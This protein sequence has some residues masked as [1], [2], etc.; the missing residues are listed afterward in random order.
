ME[1]LICLR[2]GVN[3]RFF[4]PAIIKKFPRHARLF[5]F[6]FFLEKKSFDNLPASLKKAAS[7]LPGRYDLKGI[8]DIFTSFFFFEEFFPKQ[9]WVVIDAGA[10]KGIYTEIC[11][12][13]VEN[14][15][16]I[17]SI[18]P[19]PSSSE[20]LRKKFKSQNQSNIKIVEAALGDQDG[21][22]TFYSS[23]DFSSTSS[24]DK[25][26]V[27]KFSTYFKSTRVRQCTL[28]TLI[29]EDQIRQVDIVKLDVE[30]AEF[31]ALLGAKKCLNNGVIKRLVIE[32][33][34]DVVSTKQI[35]DLL[36]RYPYHLSVVINTS[37]R[38]RKYLYAKYKGFL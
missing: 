30:G 20:Y 32:V 29:E 33:H 14:E 19:N 17:I 34:E 26:H 27:I 13:L 38:L 23:K 4:I 15:G 24:I 2:S 28:D 21:Y 36:S 7:F 31:K 3:P 11:S 6:F 16:E 8:Y 5:P 25:N 12:Q 35:K 22:I 18:E 1:C 37:A 9:G 10:Y